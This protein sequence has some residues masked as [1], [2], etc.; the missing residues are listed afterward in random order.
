MFKEMAQN[1]EEENENKNENN[2]QKDNN[3]NNI[4]NKENNQNVLVIEKKSMKKLNMMK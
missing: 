1:C 3:I 2:N 4:N